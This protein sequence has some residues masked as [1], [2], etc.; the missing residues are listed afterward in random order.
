MCVR[1]GFALVTAAVSI[2]GVGVRDKGIR[3]PSRAKSH[4]V[5]MVSKAVHLFPELRFQSLQALC[6]ADGVLQ[7]YSHPV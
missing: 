4:D 5:Q 7:L 1:F 6:S 3:L 2:A